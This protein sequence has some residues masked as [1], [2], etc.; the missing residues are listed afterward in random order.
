MESDI[1]QI[2][3]TDGA[4]ACR[5]MDLD[6]R[7]LG[8]VREEGEIGDKGNMKYRVVVFFLEKKNMSMNSLAILSYKYLKVFLCI[9]LTGF[10]MGAFSSLW[11][12]I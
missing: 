1:F 11:Y 3:P 9:L 4:K 6:S 12:I 7:R 10:A 5:P 8:L 2:L